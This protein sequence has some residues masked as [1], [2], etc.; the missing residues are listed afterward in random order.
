MGDLLE[1]WAKRNLDGQFLIEFAHKA[2]LEALA[3]FTFTARELPQTRQV[4]ALQALSNKKFLL[5]ENQPGS[6]V[7]GLSG[8]CSC[9]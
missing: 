8:Q 4:A 6:D 1:E 5:M 2:G 9:R 7:D 3:W